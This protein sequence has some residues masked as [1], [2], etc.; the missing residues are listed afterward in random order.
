MWESVLDLI[1][2]EVKMD[3]IKM[4]KN[5]LSTDEY[6]Y[7]QFVAP[8]FYHFEQD[9]KSLGRIIWRRLKEIDGIYIKK[10]EE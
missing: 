3:S 1:Y 7:Y 2:G 10:D 8:Q 5:P 9:S 4:Y 6:G